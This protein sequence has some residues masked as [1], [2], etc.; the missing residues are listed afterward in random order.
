MRAA[1]KRVMLAPPIL[2]LFAPLPTAVVAAGGALAAAAVP[3]IASATF[4]N[5]EK[6]R[7]ELSSEL[8]AL[9]RYKRQRQCERAMSD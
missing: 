2:I 5:A 7:A 8:M 9:G 6:L 4:W 1:T 3:L